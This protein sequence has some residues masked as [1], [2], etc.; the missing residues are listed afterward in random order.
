MK[1]LVTY[2]FRIEHRSEK[3]M[4]Y[5]DYLS[6]INQTNPEYLWNR[7]DAKYILNVLYN[8]KEVYG[9]ERY[10]DSMKELIQVPCGKV[11]S[12]EM[13]YQAACRETREETGLHTAPVYLTTDKGFNCDLYTTDIEERIPQWM[14]PSKNGPWTFYTWAEWEVLVNQ[15]ELTPSLITNKR[16]IR[17]VTSKKK[18]QLEHL[19]HRI[20]IIEC[21]T[22]EK[23]MKE[24]QDHYCP[25]AREIDPTILTDKP[26][27]DTTHSGPQ[28]LSEITE[29]WYPEFQDGYETPS[30]QEAPTSQKYQQG[31]Q[32]AVELENDNEESKWDSKMDNYDEESKEYYQEHR[33]NYEDPQ[34]KQRFRRVIRWREHR[35]ERLDRRMGTESTA[36]WHIIQKSTKRFVRFQKDL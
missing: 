19:I 3:K 32:S 20:I 5:A 17:R 23:M 34:M 14:E 26:W 21:P 36:S 12:E 29:E 33:A 4:G 25:P 24:N 8:D 2:F 10:K 30:Q 9:S 1:V 35:A 11:N 6:R 22:C 31:P 28:T 16:D 15:A 7:K 18:K 27:W 13:S